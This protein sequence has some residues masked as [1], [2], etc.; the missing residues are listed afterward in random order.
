MKFRYG[1]ALVGLACAVFL[2]HTALPRASA[3]QLNFISDTISDSRPSFGA[4]HT[5]I[6]NATQAIPASGQIVF[7]F[8]DRPFTFP[9]G[10]GFGDADLAVSTSSPTTGFVDRP[11]AANP[12]ATNDGLSVFAVTGP[13]TVTLSSGSGI[14][15]G[16]YVRLKFGAN[17]S[18]GGA[19][20][21]QIVN[22]SSTASYHVLINTY[23]AS[24]A[25]IDYGTT[26]VVILP[27]VSMQMS[28]NRG[29]PPNLSNA[30]P[31]GT[32]PSNISAVLVSFNT[33]TYATCRYATSSGVS[34]D[35]MTNSITHNFVGTLQTFTVSGITQGV[36]YTYYT[37]CSDAASNTSTVDYVISFTAGNPTGVSPGG[38]QYGTSGGGGGGGGAPFP[39]GPEAGS[40]SLTVQGVTLPSARVSLLKD[41]TTVPQSATAD[42]SGN[43]TVTLSSLDQ[44]VYSFTLYINDANGNRISSRT[45][46]MTIILGTANSVV[47]LVMPP[48]IDLATTTVAVGKTV[49]ISGQSEPLSTVELWVTSQKGA[50]SPI[51]V[52]IPADGGGSWSYDLDTTGFP[53]DT[54]QVKARSS[55]PGLQVSNFSNIQFL[56]V[57]QKPVPQVANADL[58]G[59]GKV[60]LVDFSILLFHWGQNYPPADFNFDGTVSLP[61]FSILLFHWTG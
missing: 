59:D 8:R 46:T 5:I 1:F 7:D 34:Y 14:P 61:D 17:A 54:Y 43:F 27:A 52:T 4:D 11:L 35:L 24:N 57:G 33:D 38:G 37:R 9:L 58:N 60:N 28:N 2:F 56:G 36:T 26:I 30:L 41:G 45:F 6:F 55:V 10:S 31:T 48:T 23:D 53:V 49:T 50:Q 42:A 13:I 32:I 44:G 25:P 18:F 19:G 21:H 3:D 40:A 20:V 47:G 29:I 39:P 15:A 16:A 22:P 12:D 51:T